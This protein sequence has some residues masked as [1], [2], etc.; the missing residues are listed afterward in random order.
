MKKLLLATILAAGTTLASFGAAVFTEGFGGA[1]FLFN[2]AAEDFRLSLYAPEG[3]IGEIGL[4]D[5]TTGQKILADST[6][7]F[8]NFSAGDAVG[9]WIKNQDFSTSGKGTPGPGINAVVAE[10]S[11]TEG[12]PGAYTFSMAPYFGGNMEE[13][14][15]MNF[16]LWQKNGQGNAWG[17]TPF[18]Y[19]TSWGL[20]A[21]N[22]PGGSG[23]P[24]PGVLAALAITGV[25]AA[26]KFR[27]QK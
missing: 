11:S 12:G 25:V 8:G 24:L 13:E 16:T 15:L 4:Y 9:I 19:G 17:N 10:Y 2:S 6:G 5:I 18:V 14:F 20:L 23:Q 26:L 1:Y 27:R 21:T 7:S 3:K 22:A